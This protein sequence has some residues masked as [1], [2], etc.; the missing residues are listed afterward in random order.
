MANFTQGTWTQQEDNLGCKQI[1]SGETEI[2]YTVGLSDEDEDQ[3][4]ADLFK[5]AP[6][7]YKAL[8]Q[9]AYSMAQARVLGN[10][11]RRE[12]LLT[13]DTAI[14]ALAKVDGN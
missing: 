2:C 5:S 13:E 11:T 3:A 8:Q 6:I 4:N 1:V 12:I 9:I 10:D 14:A 7:L